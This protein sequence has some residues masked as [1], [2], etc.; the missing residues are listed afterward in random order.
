MSLRN[1]DAPSRRAFVQTQLTIL[2]SNIRGLPDAQKLDA[3]RECIRQLRVLHEE[4][5]IQYAARLF[6]QHHSPPADQSYGLPIQSL[7]PTEED[8]AGLQEER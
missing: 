6:Q 1:L 2:K 8:P 3:L 5:E 4:I 7:W